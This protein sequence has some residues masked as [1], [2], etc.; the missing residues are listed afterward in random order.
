MLAETSSPTCP[1]SSRATATTTSR[2][3]EVAAVALRARRGGAGVG[4]GV[5]DRGWAEGQRSGKWACFWHR[6]MRHTGPGGLVVG[7]VGE[8]WSMTR[9]L[10]ATTWGSG[11]V[12]RGA[13]S[14]H[15]IYSGHIGGAGRQ[16]HSVEA[17][18][19]VRFRVTAC[20]L[21][22][23]GRMCD[24]RPLLREGAVLSMVFGWRGGSPPATMQSESH[25]VL[26]CVA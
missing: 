15:K 3:V 9:N 6:G 14:G 2:E 5:S 10:R 12:G 18:C 19:V 20:G 16:P 13:P 11:P 21:G 26:S 23:R 8:C 1:P 4:T 7:C 24:H 25:T 17:Q 22:R